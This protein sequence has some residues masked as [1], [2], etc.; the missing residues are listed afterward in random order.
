MEGRGRKEGG[1]I[2]THSNRKKAMSIEHGRW[3]R[4]QAKFPAPA[5]LTLSSMAKVAIGVAVCPLPPLKP[6]AAA[7]LLATDRLR[8]EDDRDVVALREAFERVHD[9]V[10]LRP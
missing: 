6:F 1:S 9:I 8:D 2:N 4:A 10:V 7:R 3:Q 5:V